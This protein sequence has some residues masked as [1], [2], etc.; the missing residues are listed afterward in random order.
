MSKMGYSMKDCDI[1]EAVHKK[2]LRRHHANPKTLIID[3]L[4]LKH[5]TCRADIAVV[6]GWLSGFEIKSDKDSLF[7]LENQAEVYNAV[8]NYI[9]IVAGESH[10]PSVMDYVSDWWGIIICTKGPRG[11]IKFSTVRKPIR[12]S[13]IDPFSV[14]QLLWK[15]E[16][17]EILGNRGIS[18]KFFRL[19]RSELYEFL[20]SV[21]NPE[22]LGRIVRSYLKKRRNWKGH[23]PLFPRDDSYQPISM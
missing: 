6:N 11:A 12:N 9:T 3:E 21:L 23:R 19:Q 8:F 20:C 22:G 17:V 14:A 15:N 18:P 13:T 1:R 7:R 5:G 4:G 2:I 16:I 10:F